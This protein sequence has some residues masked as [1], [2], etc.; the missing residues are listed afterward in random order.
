LTRELTRE[1]TLELTVGDIGFDAFVDHFVDQFFDFVGIVGINF[2][3][4]HSY[5]ALFV[6]CLHIHYSL[7]LRFDYKTF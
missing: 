3:R 5:K 4:F 6:F 1:L 7:C 2:S